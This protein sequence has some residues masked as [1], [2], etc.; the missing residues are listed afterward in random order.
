MIRV[1]VIFMGK[2]RVKVYSR[3]RSKVGL[4][5]ELRFVYRFE[6]G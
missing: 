1:R 6:L 4:G 2:V 3:F 5:L